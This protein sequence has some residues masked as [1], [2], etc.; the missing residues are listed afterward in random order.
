MRRSVSYGRGS[1]F[2]RD[3]APGQRAGYELPLGPL[4]APK[5]RPLSV[6]AVSVI[7][8]RMDPCEIL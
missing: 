5:A 6:V 7:S 4:H 1:N 3:I 8:D 2:I